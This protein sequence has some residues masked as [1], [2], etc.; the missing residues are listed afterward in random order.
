MRLERDHPV[1]VRECLLGR[2]GVSG[3]PVVYA[4]VGLTLL[5]VADDRGVGLQRPLRRGHPRQ[6]L[7]ADLDELE[8]VVRHVRVLGDDAGDLL[9]LHADL[10]GGEHG[11]RVAGQGRH[12][13]EVVLGEQLAR[14]HRDDARQ[15][16]RR[17]GVYRVDASMGELRAQD[18]HVQH[19][20]E[21]DVVDVVAAALEEAL[22]LL[23]LDAVTD[24]RVLSAAHCTAWTMF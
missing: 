21:L 20:R 14:H 16:L 6:R 19:P 17:R 10:V 1:G 23:A 4:V 9:A 18:R 3:L 7:V 13:G 22:V 8:R 12:P 11:L 2:G 15:R 5:V 24:H